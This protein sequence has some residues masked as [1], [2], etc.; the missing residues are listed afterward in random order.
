[1]SFFKN[2]VCY[3]PSDAS[4]G[5]NGSTGGDLTDPGAPSG[6]AGSGEGQDGGAAEGSA[7][8][9]Y[10]D[11]A[12]DERVQAY[13]HK[14]FGHIPEEHRSPDA[15]KQLLG[16]RD[17]VGTLQQQLQQLQQLQQRAQGGEQQPAV[18]KA[19][20]E[21]ILASVEKAWGAPIKPEH[22]RFFGHM[23]D[24]I[25]KA[26]DGHFKKTYFAPIQQ[27]LQQRALHDEQQ[28][29]AALPGYKEHELEIRQIV[30]QSKGAIPFDQAYKI[31]MYDK[32]KKS[33]GGSIAASGA[34]G[35]GAASGTSGK[36]GSQRPVSDGDRPSGASASGGKMP[37][38]KSP[39]EAT[40]GAAGALRRLGINVRR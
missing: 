36:P 7:E 14:Q 23:I 30:Y 15:F 9:D 27:H 35:A 2:L 12:G 34:P 38:Y 32:Q 37:K 3:S 4:G 5:G 39:E 33:A 40:N 31:V 26:M 29:A 6:D 28:R 22:K 8:D 11:L 16:H 17:Q 19:F 21:D 25:H 18:E 1:M 13:L 20:H 24:S 10:S